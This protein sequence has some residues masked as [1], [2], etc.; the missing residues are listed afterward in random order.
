MLTWDNCKN[1]SRTDEL[2]LKFLRAY[3]LKLY[4]NRRQSGAFARHA[5][6]C[7][8]LWNYLLDKQ[9]KQFEIDQT[10]IFFHDMSKMLPGLKGEFPWLAE[11]PS[12][13][14]VRVCR[15]LDMAMRKCF[16]QG[17]GF[18]RF[19]VRGRSRASFYIINQALRIDDD[20]RK[21]FLP[22]TGEVNFR[23][24]RLPEGDI[25][26][27]NVAWNGRYW[28]LTVQC[29]M[30]VEPPIVIPQAATVIGVDLGLKEL[31]VR[32]DGVVVKP[33]KALRKSFKRLRRAQRCLARRKKASANRTKQA[34]LVGRIHALARQMR[35]DG[36]HKA[37]SSLVKAASAIVTETLNV[38]GMVKNKRLSLSISD[39]G[40]GE[41]VRQI[42]YK[43]EWAGK[44]HLKANRFEPSTQTCSACKLV[45]SGDDKLRLRHRIFRCDCGAELD[46]D[47]NSALN[48]RHLGLLALGLMKNDVGQAMPER[49]ARRKR[50]NA[51]ACGDTSDGR[52]APATLSHVSW[53]QELALG[54]TENS[55]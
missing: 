18:P 23:T 9:K 40:W 52:V 46:R 29:K 10:F 44:R 20:R 53:K 39:A 47:H 42:G 45:K 21:V 27:A 2:K 19:K 36:Q 54:S 26:G 1:E 30:S 3:K 33:S 16:K 49:A 8:W 6:A 28:E 37:T 22:K 38:K 4:P 31:M 11:A 41:I 55:G 17:A 43:A 25:A 7:R 51:D 34:R 5:G 15:N 24:G 50:R 35:R 14:L 13:S 32:S 48:L 12:N